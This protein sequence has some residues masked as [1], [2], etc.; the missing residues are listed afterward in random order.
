[1]RSLKSL[2]EKV[3]VERADA[4]RIQA[5]TPPIIVHD[6]TPQ[7]LEEPMM[8]HEETAE[9]LH[10]LTNTRQRRQLRERGTVQFIH[11]FRRTIGAQP[12]PTPDVFSSVW[13]P[14]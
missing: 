5:G 1:M 11:T 8:S 6:G 13:L 7:M 12:R 4:L 10:S 2:L 14:C 9:L 3:R